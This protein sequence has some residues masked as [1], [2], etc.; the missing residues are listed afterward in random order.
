VA[1]LLTQPSL[2]SEAEMLQDVFAKALIRHYGKSNQP[3][4]CASLILK[5]G[6]HN[7]SGAIRIL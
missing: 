6:L 3:L 2:T 7:S 4:L 5:G 1:I